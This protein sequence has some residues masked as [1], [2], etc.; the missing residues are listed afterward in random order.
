MMEGIS[1]MLPLLIGASMKIA[2][3]LF[4]WRAFGDVKPP[5]EV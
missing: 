3:D 5:E 1:L 2:Y 4:L